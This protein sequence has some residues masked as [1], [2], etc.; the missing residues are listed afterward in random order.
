M[1]I[2]GTRW[3]IILALLSWTASVARAQPES[4][5]QETANLERMP[6]GFHVTDGPA[7]TPALGYNGY[8]QRPRLARWWQ[9]RAKPC[10]QYSYWGYADEFEEVPL[11]ASVRAHQQAQICSGWSARL[12]LYQY[13]FCDGGAA[14]NLHGQQRLNDM[15]AAFPIWAEHH[16]L[17]IEST[18][19]KPYLALARREHVIKVLKKAGIPAQVEVGVPTGF[20]PLGEET[21]LM[22]T[23]LMSQIRS[24]GGRAGG[25]QG[26]TS[27]GGGAA[28]PAS[29]P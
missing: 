9:D 5:P 17:L 20:V 7:M 29:G 13:D 4:G 22:N 3:L 10:L 2:L 26:G 1:H 27:S 14:L 28:A 15:A 6:A 23:L 19:D 18:P 8:D 12:F 24:G 21:R 25:S 16:Q 11:G